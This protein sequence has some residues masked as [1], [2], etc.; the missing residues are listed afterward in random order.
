MEVI[1]DPFTAKGFPISEQNHL[2]LDRVK[3]ISVSGTYWRERVIGNIVFEWTWMFSILLE[4]IKPLWK[5]LHKHNASKISAKA[6]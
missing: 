3:F 6:F 5:A 1:L 4:L 2:A